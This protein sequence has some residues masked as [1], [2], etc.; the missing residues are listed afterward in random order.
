M[1]VGRREANLCLA[2]CPARKFFIENWKFLK[3]LKVNK[4]WKNVIILSWMMKIEEILITLSK[5]SQHY[6]KMSEKMFK[7]RKN[8]LKF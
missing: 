5:I 7:L 8:R 6:L 3:I 1:T 2:H 4:L